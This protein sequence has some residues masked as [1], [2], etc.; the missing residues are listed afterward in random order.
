MIKNPSTQA[1]GMKY[2]F[3]FTQ[4]LASASAV[5]VTLA[6]GVFFLIS[7]Y[8]VILH[9][10]NP[11][12]AQDMDMAKYPFALRW[13]FSHLDSLFFGLATAIIMFQSKSD[14]QKILYCVFE[15]IMIFLN[16]NQNYIS[17]FLG[18]SS[19]FLLGT[20]IA[21]F[22]G[23]TLYFL[24]TLAKQHNQTEAQSEP[25]NNTSPTKNIVNVFGEPYNAPQVTPTI[26]FQMKGNTAIE[27]KEPEKNRK[28]RGKS[29][30]YAR[31]NDL[32]DKGFTASEVARLLKCNESSIYK[33]KAQRK[34]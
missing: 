23:F 27:A 9:L 1:N 21:V 14:R 5:S 24:G 26:G 4:W 3:S 32:L 20:Y 12:N 13:L 28:P 17:E 8:E 33:I 30:D 34:E 15:A 11:Q 2:S 29:I 6:I 31:V 18:T 22:S 16:L 10:T 7:N 25:N 19:H